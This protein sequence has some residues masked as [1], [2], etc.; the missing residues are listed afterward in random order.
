MKQGLFTAAAFIAGMLVMFVLQQVV[1]AAEEQPEVELPVL[2]YHD[3]QPGKADSITVPPDVFEEQLA[4]LNEAGYTSITLEEIHAYR[5]EGAAL[6]EKPVLITFDDGY[7]SNYEYA[8]PA[9]QEAGMHAVIFAIA[10]RRES[11]ADNHFTWEEAREMEAEGTVSI[12]HHTYDMHY[13]HEGETGAE[14]A[15]LISRT[16][17]ETELEY[18]M[19]VRA[20]L[21]KAKELMEM[22]LD[23]P[24]T[25]FS[26]PFGKYNE[27]SVDISREMGMPLLFTI[28]PVMNEQEHLEAGM[29]HRFNVPGDMNGDEL[30][31]MLENERP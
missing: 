29:L 5:A 30:I 16:P 21:A 20:D 1:F 8:Y 28:H 25:A 6:P 10:E 26:F 9:L 18:E 17:E 2:M 22:E 15:S 24:V 27:F 3:F 31:A 4:A 11:G 13:L 14:E 12:Q 7:R 19:R 23:T